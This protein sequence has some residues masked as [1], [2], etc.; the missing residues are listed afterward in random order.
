MGSL[1]AALGRRGRSATAV[2]VVARH[3][4][5]A[6]AT[7]HAAK[8]R[9]APKLRDIRTSF[10]KTP[11]SVTLNPQTAAAPQQPAAPPSVPAP[12]PEVA[13][14]APAPLPISL[15]GACSSSAKGQ[16]VVAAAAVDWSS[17]APSLAALDRVLDGLLLAPAPP[18]PT[19]APAARKAA[20]P[21]KGRGRAA[22]GGEGAAVVS[23]MCEVEWEREAAA[24]A[25]AGQLLVVKA[26]GCR[27][28]L[29][30]PGAGDG[31]GSS[32]PPAL[33]A[34][35]ASHESFSPSGGSYGVMA[36]GA[37]SSFIGGAAGFGGVGSSFG[38]AA[39]FG[40]GSGFGGA[41][42][43]FG[44]VGSGFGGAGSGFGGALGSLGSVD[45]GGPAPG[46]LGLGSGACSG[47]GGGA[48]AGA[49]R[50]LDSPV[51]RWYTELASA[52]AAAPLPAGAGAAPFRFISLQS[53]TP[54]AKAL[55]RRLGVS[56]CLSV[57]V[58]EPVSGRKLL[59][60]CGTKIEAD[61]P[62]GLLFLG[63]AD[64]RGE[65]PSALLPRIGGRAALEAH[66]R[67][68]DVAVVAFHCAAAAPCV[69]TYGALHHAA[70][71]HAG[72]V[73]FAVLDVDANGEAAALGGELALERLPTYAIYRAGAEVAR[74]AR[75]SERR[76]LGEALTAVLAAPAPAPAATSARAPA[77]LAGGLSRRAGSRAVPGA[78]STA[79]S[80]PHPARPR[81][82]DA[83]RAPTSLRS[84]TPT[85]APSPAP[86]RVAWAPPQRPAAAAA[87]ML[88]VRGLA[89]HAVE[90]SDASDSE[91]EDLTSPAPIA[92][93]AARAA[94]QQDVRVPRTRRRRGRG[95]ADGGGARQ[96][97]APAAD[98]RPAAAPAAAPPPPRRAVRLPGSLARALALLAL[99]GVGAALLLAG[100]APRAGPAATSGAHG[101]GGSLG[102]GLGS[103]LAGLAF[104]AAAPGAWLRRRATAAGGARAAA[105]GRGAAAQ[106][107]AWPL[108]MHGGGGGRQPGGGAAP[109]AAAVGA[110]AA[111]AGGW[112][113]YAPGEAAA[114]AAQMPPP[115]GA[116]PRGEAIRMYAVVDASAASPY[117]GAPWGEV[118][119]HMARRLAW[120][121][122]RFALT[123][124]DAAALAADPAARDALAAGLAEPT[125]GGAGAAR[126]L[127][128]FVAVGVTDPGVAEFLA[129]ATAAL[130]TA[131]FWESAP[132]LNDATRVDGF[133]PATAGPLARALAARVGFSAE[134]RAAGVLG[135]LRT[136]WDRHTSDDLLFT[137]LVLI[138]QYFTPVPDVANTTKGTDLSSL[139]CMVRHCGPK[140]ADCVSDPTCKAGLDCLQG[141]SF[142][143]QVCQYRCI[144]SH[145]TPK[146]SDFALCILQLHN[147]RGLNAQPPA[148]PD[149]APM[150]SFRGA[151]LTHEA[152]EA[153]FIGWR[154][155]GPQLPPGAG[156]GALKPWSWLVAAGKNPAY[157]YFPCQHQLYS[158][159]KG[160]G[161]MWYEP[162]FKAVTLDGRQV[163]RRRRY[164]VRRGSVPGT[165]NY[166]VLDNGVT[167]NEFWRILDCAEDLS[168]CLFYYSGAAA[169]AGLSYSGA[170]LA[171]PDGAWP[172]VHT[173]RVHG[174]L[175]RAGIAPWELSLVDNTACA[176][177]PL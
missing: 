58:V 36:P 101:L 175:A 21:R 120:S 163:W 70:R 127:P 97:L 151:P 103:G 43:G 147:C 5:A 171:T 71:A 86:D 113:S 76:A 28:L 67:S 99:L 137:W 149:P 146:F 15:G 111:A 47:P 94:A 119:A 1:D 170:V 128:L 50:G 53:D 81:P 139:L 38:G 18:P 33:A 126:R 3:P 121:D 122:A 106:R 172:A 51:H 145:E 16:P 153:L 73:P 95:S 39:G 9:R 61:L 34:Y 41:G 91:R 35:L 144:V 26:E 165:F 30:G 79:G 8:P 11:G 143:D 4:K 102:R 166:S 132:A 55:C 25:A 134:A 32:L 157:D 104:R 20:A 24:A 74:L 68:A 129:S 176:G 48:C 56:E 164:R 65:R 116:A 66:V 42:S 85:Y 105:G 12:P 29:R 161:Q 123:V 169:A 177:A 64:T 62:S 59:E 88:V 162:V 108:S 159:G 155:A 37:G 133:A 57:L 63:D 54:R 14:V 49:A 174:A 23:I 45:F 156:A 131:L 2:E 109:L 154:E 69:K 118:A 98:A 10:L 148:L 100:R 115:P 17:E 173:A 168:F 83:P 152:A 40:A 31:H 93:A 72:G 78:R 112:D 60:V 89:S 6:R 150:G 77:M 13:A 142:N 158:Y 90:L 92:T 80:I 135:T 82:V 52:Y 84:E 46:A 87:P 125:G 138:N 136:L 124:V 160:K 167:S 75:T 19:A 7:T 114:L 27:N 44:G 110:A 130:P 141:C 117:R 107:S 140:I 96:Q 22:A